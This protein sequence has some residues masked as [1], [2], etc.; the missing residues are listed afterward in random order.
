MKS[1]NFR[2]FRA[3]GMTS[4]AFQE[5]LDA[6]KKIQQ[7]VEENASVFT[8]NM[9]QNYMLLDQTLAKLKAQKK[10]AKSLRETARNFNEENTVKFLKDSETQIDKLREKLAPR[11]GR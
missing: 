11:T 10:E 3:S 6:F 4:P 9:K 8:S 2:K 7:Q 1:Q 5:K